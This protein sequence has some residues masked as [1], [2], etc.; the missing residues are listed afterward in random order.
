MEQKVIAKQLFDFMATMW[1]V[2]T[3]DN[4]FTLSQSEQNSV[5]HIANQYAE[6]FAEVVAGRAVVVEVEVA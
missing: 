6:L 4:F 3:S 5:S 1:E 2:R